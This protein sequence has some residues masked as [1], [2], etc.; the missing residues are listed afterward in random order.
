MTVPEFLEWDSGDDRTYELHDGVVVAMAP[1]SR[2]HNV[3]A[4][5]LGFHIRGALTGR[6]GCTVEPQAGIRSR[7]RE[8]SFYVCDLAVSCM[9]PRPGE[10]EVAEPILI[11]EIL[12][13][14]T[15]AADRRLK[16]PDYRL[17]PSV[18]EILL[19]EQEAI[20]CELHRRLDDQRWVTDLVQGSEQVLR[21]A[22]VGLEIPL[23][24][25]YRD[26]PLSSA[27]TG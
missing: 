23:G 25:L 7:R 22:S 27:E 21:L 10:K 3:I 17:I 9:P 19:L 20:F 2:P 18:Q 1:A 16:L 14:S 24:Q 13:P 4:G 8:N 6:R 5:E 15:G 12:S 11:V 26:V